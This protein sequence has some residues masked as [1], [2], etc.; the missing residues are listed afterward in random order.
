MGVLM[1]RS[2]Q[3]AKVVRP[4]DD[5]TYK[6]SVANASPMGLCG[7]VAHGFRWVQA[8]NCRSRGMK[9]ISEGVPPAGWKAHLLTALTVVSGLV[10]AALLL[11]TLDRESQPI[12]ERAVTGAQGNR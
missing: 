5:S 6:A 12:Q 9:V 10:G 1:L 4:D 7:R 8:S 2:A 11:G 3:P